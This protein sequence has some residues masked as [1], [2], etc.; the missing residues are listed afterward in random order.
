MTDRIPHPDYPD[1]DTKGRLLPGHDHRITTDNHP[2][3][4]QARKDK[5]RKAND[6]AV[7]VAIQSVEHG[8]D[9]TEHALAAIV[10]QHALNALDP[11]AR[12]SVQSA[13]LAL[14]ETGRSQDKQT[15]QAGRVSGAFDMAALLV[16]ALGMEQ[17]TRTVDAHWKQVTETEP[18][19]DTT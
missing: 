2:E 3:Y 13:K 18:D 1:R 7:L 8:V 10:G 19:T 16:A 9:D 6:H 11:S 17:Q 5:Q 4:T 14:E 12:N 15:F